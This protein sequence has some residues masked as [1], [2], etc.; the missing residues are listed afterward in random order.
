MPQTKT[1]LITG[2]ASGIGRK[3]AELFASRGWLV[4]AA[5]INPA[6]L[7]KLVED[8]GSSNVIPL[9][10]NVSTKEEA[11]AMVQSFLSHTGG[12]LDCLF[13]CAGVLFMGPHENITSEQ[14]KLLIDVN[15]NGVIHCTDAAFDA[16]K[17]TPK[18][19]IVSMCSASSEFGAPHHAVY[20]A[21]KAFVR[22]FTE[23]LNV[24][25]SQHDIQVSDIV[26]AYVQTPM[27]FDAQVKA[28]SI[29]KLGVKVKP[30]D[31]A[32]RV[33]EAA[34]GNKT[35]WYVGA[36]SRLMNLVVRALGQKSK[37]VYQALGG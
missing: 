36:D 14:K 35:H 1:I 8:I 10:S 24:E 27:V 30:E 28:K 19:H 33:W 5:D 25:F 13:N 15:V 9:V 11:D 4:G 22:N 17:N 23:A 37:Y 16:L 3:T 21:T 12:T 31:V 7:D 26:V 34:H 20:G 29:E 32:N 6:A 18:A 2:A